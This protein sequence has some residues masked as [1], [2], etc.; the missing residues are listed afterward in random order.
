MP[1][2]IKLSTT[3][4][5]IG[6]VTLFFILFLV[7]A[8]KT[9]TSIKTQNDK[10]AIIYLSDV[11]PITMLKKLSD[12]Y[13]IDIVDTIH[14]TRSKNISFEEGK[15]HILRAISNTDDIWN[16]FNEHRIKNQSYNSDIDQKIKK[17]EQSKK[18]ENQFIQKVL[19]L[20]DSKD[21]DAINQIAAEELYPS[22]EPMTLLLSNL[23]DL[24]LQEAKTEMAKNDKEYDDLI[25]NFIIIFAIAIFGGLGINIPL[26]RNISRDEEQL[27]EN[28]QNLK[29]SNKNLENEQNKI[30]DFTNFLSS[31]N[32]VDISYIAQKALQHIMKATKSQIALFYYYDENEKLKLLAKDGVDDNALKAS[33]FS[34]ITNGLPLESIQDNKWIT[35]EDIDL[36]ALPKI[37]LGFCEGTITQVM[38]IPLIFQGEKIGS[39][40]LAGLSNTEFRK[41]YLKGYIDALLHSL[42]NAKS[43][44]VTQRQAVNLEQANMQLQE[45]NKLKSEFMANMSHELRTPLNSIIGF[46]SILQKNKK[47]NLS[48]KETTQIGTINRNG[49][50]LLSLINNI[51]DLSK[52]EAGK[53]EIE[54]REFNL[55]ECLNDVVNMLHPQ[56]EDKKIAL[57]F[58][59]ESDDVLLIHN[60]EQKI[61]QIV[62]NLVNNALKFVEPGSG[63]VEVVLSKKDSIYTIDVKDNGIGIAKEK[64]EHI[65]KAFRQADGSTTRKYGGTGLGLTISKDM[66]EH[67][68]GRI[69]VESE[70]GQGALFKVSLIDINDDSS[71]INLFK[72]LDAVEIEMHQNKT[73]DFTKE[74]KVALIIED[75]T[76]SQELMKSYLE[77]FGFNIL[78]AE[79][80]KKGLKIMNEV[81]PDLIILDI[82]LPEMNGWEVLNNMK[83]EPKL[84]STPV[85]VVSIVADKLKAFRLGASECLTKPVSKEDIFH[86][87][88]AMTEGN[89]TADI[90][91][92]DDDPDLLEI[93]ENYLENEAKNIK[94]ALNGVEALDILESGFIPDIIY[95]DLMMPEMDG[96]EFLEIIRN[97]E[98]FF[99]LP[100]VVVSAKE[101]TLQEKEML[102]KRGVN[103]LAKGESTEKNMHTLL[104]QI[105][106]SNGN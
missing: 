19:R 69:D 78:L 67:L 27:K 77:E 14:K 97:D 17:F 48:E 62:I 11:V 100:V 2:S 22:I 83:H 92:V 81:E 84:A 54:L 99:S 79:D 49:K 66:V 51:L 96:F 82:M 68:G 53:M 9:L 103:I 106:S 73:F 25:K 95:L 45:T 4:K 33:I 1:F 10:F 26:I 3:Q 87:L 18:I 101:I 89:N 43:F 20:Y 29:E 86:S 80:G 16:E 59:N 34:N 39:I 56:A 72:S 41:E 5:I 24:H 28:T 40:V 60:D 30:L 23:I 46:S 50:H 64:Q 71:S 85:I 8:I 94:K 13:A 44:A 55:V 102:K 98:R 104:N 35:I 63:K 70:D 21:I 52:I 58:N 36:K 15:R 65:F 93:Y 7:V 32:S 88:K 37:N 90:L 6:L 12:N 31:L 75:D 76:D 42:K 38:A 105:I 57:I 47:Q 61:K 74:T 91:L